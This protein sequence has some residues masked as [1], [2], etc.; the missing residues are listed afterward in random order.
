MMSIKSLLYF[1]DKEMLKRISELVAG[2][3]SWK[4]APGKNPSLKNTPRKTVSWKITPRI[5]V[6]L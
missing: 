5:F 3:G 4:N 1:H 6:R 2:T